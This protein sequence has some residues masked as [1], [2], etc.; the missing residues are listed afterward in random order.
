MEESSAQDLYT[1][2]YDADRPELFMKDAGCRRTVGPGRGD[3]RA[4]R[5][6]L[7]RPEPEIGVVLARAARWSG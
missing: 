6:R 4:R 5:L 7:G 2:V 1:L 3:R